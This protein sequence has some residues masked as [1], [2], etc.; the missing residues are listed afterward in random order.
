M[1]KDVCGSNLLNNKG[2]CL[3]SI[4][5]YVCVAMHMSRPHH[6]FI[7]VELRTAI[8]SLQGSFWNDYWY[9]KKESVDAETR[10]KYGAFVDTLRKILP[11]LGTREDFFILYDACV[12]T[13]WLVT[14]LEKWKVSVTQ[15]GE[16]DLVTF[17][18]GVIDKLGTIFTL[19]TTA[20]EGHYEWVQMA[21]MSSLLHQLKTISD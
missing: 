9:D 20:G 7:S 8:T 13:E 11:G 6:L 18:Q 2:D 15:N 21:C 19:L 1:F 4:D 14:Y 16:K 5:I 17:I 3:Y 10:G 12:P